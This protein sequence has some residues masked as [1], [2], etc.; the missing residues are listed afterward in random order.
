MVVLSMAPI[1]SS[2]LAE[3]WMA[4]K[5]SDLNLGLGMAGWSQFVTSFR[6]FTERE[7]F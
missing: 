2:A 7:I 5:A 3:V 6:K 1:L 4:W